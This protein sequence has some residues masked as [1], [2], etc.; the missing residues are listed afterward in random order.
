VRL[1]RIQGLRLAELVAA[2]SLATD[3]G[4]GQPMEHVLRSQLSGRRR[5]G[6]DRPG[7]VSQAV[8]VLVRTIEGGADRSTGSPFLPIGMDADLRF[9]IPA[10]W[11]PHSVCRRDSRQAMSLSRAM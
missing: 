11:K 3:L 7:A 1:I 4:M 2:F 5:R 8:A 9:S 6:R 10:G